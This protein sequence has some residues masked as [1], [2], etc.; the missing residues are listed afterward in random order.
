MCMA[1]AS[2]EEAKKKPVFVLICSDV[3]ISKKNFTLGKYPNCDDHCRSTADGYTS[4]SGT[5]KPNRSNS[6]TYF[7]TFSYNCIEGKLPGPWKILT[8]LS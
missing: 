7:C 4:T 2:H 3:T 8:C 1:W 5:F 6:V